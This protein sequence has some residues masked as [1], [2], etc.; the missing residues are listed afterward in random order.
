M[1]QTKHTFFYLAKKVNH[2]INL[3]GQSLSWLTLFMVLTTVL[4]VFLRYGFGIGATA[5]QESVLYAHALILLL[6]APMAFSQEAHVRVDIF[7]QRFSK[8]NQAWVNLVGTLLFLW[9]T[10]AFICNNS[11]AYVATAWA[12]KEGS[13]EPGG[14]N[15]VY[16]LKSL[17]VIFPIALLLHSINTIFA[18]ASY[19]L[20]KK[21]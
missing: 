21:S 16:G 5:V 11:W 6:C 2:A 8:K 13:A 19:L 7:Y 10:C 14:I 17:L 1:M 9:P 4:V 12:V 18:N 3:L 15:F 20:S